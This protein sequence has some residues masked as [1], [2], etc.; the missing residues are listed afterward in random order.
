M[1]QRTEEWFQERAGKVTASRFKDILPGA[2]GNYLAIR[3]NYMRQL[4]AERL[5]G[6]PKDQISAKQLDWGNEHEAAAVFA[7]E[8]EV[9]QSVTPAGFITHAAYPEAGGSP[10]GFVGTDGLI[11]IKC[12]FDPAQHIA[13]LE[14]SAW[15]DHIPQKQG[16]LWVAGK[17][18]IDFVSYCPLFPQQMQLFKRR[19]YRDEKYIS[20]LASEVCGFLVVMQNTIAELKKKYGVTA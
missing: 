2:R 7:Y 17:Q 14:D 1:L 9:G 16:N 4:I 18:W 10:D 6:K 5:T 12:P 20:M 3:D 19:F 15:E 11:E 13:Y 8:M